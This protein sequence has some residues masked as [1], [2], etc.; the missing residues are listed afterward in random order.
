MFGL[1]IYAA[2]VRRASPPPSPWIAPDW[3]CS[4]LTHK[5]GSVTR[6]RSATV[7]GSHGLPCICEQKKTP[8]VG[9]PAPWHVLSC[10]GGSVKVVDNMAVL[11]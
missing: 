8:E 3:L 7:A 11:L 6:Y 9:S 2:I 4:V 5:W 10:E 1:R